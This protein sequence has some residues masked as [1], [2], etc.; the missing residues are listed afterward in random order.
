MGKYVRSHLIFLISILL[1]IGTGFSNQKI[2]IE[3][4]NAV[5]TVVLNYLSMLA[6]PIVLLAI[7]STLINMRGLEQLRRLGKKVIAYTLLTTG[8]AALVALTCF[9][10]LDPV[11]TVQKSGEIAMGTEQRSYLH[12][13]LDI[14]P[15]NIFKAFLEN[16]VISIAFLGFLLGIAAHTLPQESRKLL[17]NGLSALFQLF[18]KIAEIIR[19]FMPLAIW[20]FMTL[21]VKDIQEQRAEISGLWIYLS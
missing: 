20:A 4:A 11:A 8:L 9:L 16:K 17:Q 18:L 21:L 2:L 7:L 12:F 6:A 5:S 14:V 15:S 3:A 1:G 10:V 13:L 19:Y